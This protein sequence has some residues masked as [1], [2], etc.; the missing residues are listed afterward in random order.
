MPNYDT[1]DTLIKD[2]PPEELFDTVKHAATHL[3]DDQLAQLRMWAYYD[4]PNRRREA[5]AEEERNQAVARGEA[6][7]ISKLVD[8]G[9]LTGNGAPTEAPEDNASIP[10]W[11][12]PGTTHSRMYLPGQLVRHN[13]R[14]WRSTHP[15]LNHWEPGTFGV[16]ERIWEEYIPDTPTIS[17]YPEWRAGMS[18]NVGDVFRF[19]GSYW[20]VRQAHR[21]QSDWIPSE[22]P[23]LYEPIAP[24]EDE[25]TPPEPSTPA[26]PIEE[27]PHAFPAVWAPGVRVV[28]GEVLNWRGTNYKVLTDHLTVEG[29]DPE[30]RPDLYE[31]QP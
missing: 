21:T 11:R 5:R 25:I 30:K 14:I 1:I 22:L 9:E 2:L 23:A 12:N 29:E 20:K 19:R 13:G 6:E 3:D 7:L 8:D 15:G 26:P 27:P 17:R 10:E 28:K 18:V 16:D 4:E 31:A 24:P